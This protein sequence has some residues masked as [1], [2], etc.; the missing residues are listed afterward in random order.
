[1]QVIARAPAGVGYVVVDRLA[2]MGTHTKHLV[3]EL[4]HA[5]SPGV[6]HHVGRLRDH[7]ALLL[8]PE[9]ED[10][11]DSVHG[12]VDPLLTTA[13]HRN[14]DDVD[15]HAKRDDIPQA[16]KHPEHGT[17]AGLIGFRPLSSKHLHAEPLGD[18]GVGIELS[19]FQVPP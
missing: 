1:M 2:L 13:L 6:R 16:Y 17:A 4:D 11:R 9:L 18:G 3:D 7:L 14:R 8:H 12:I 15:R 10:T 19:V 5:G